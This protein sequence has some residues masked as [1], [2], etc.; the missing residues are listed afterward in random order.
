MFLTVWKTYVTFILLRPH[1][2][3][4]GSALKT[5]RREVS[6][7]VTGRSCQPKPFGVFRG[8][9]RNSRKYGLGSL[10]KTPHGGHSTYSP[11][12]H[13]RTIGH[14]STTNQPTNISIDHS[15]LVKKK[16]DS[17]NACKG[18][19]ILSALCFI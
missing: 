7:S 19:D 6:G 11:R 8:F 10:T 16:T 13:K 12:S 15:L 17:F 4:G 18:L 3:R 14:K 2:G 1:Q 9:L 5:G